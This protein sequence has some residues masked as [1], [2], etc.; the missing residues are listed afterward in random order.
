MKDYQ[1]N[2][3]TEF[4]QYQYDMLYPSGI[5]NHF[6][7]KTRHKIIEHIIYK[8]KLDTTKLL[9]VGCGKGI[10]LNYLLAQQMNIFGVELAPVTPLAG[11]EKNIITG[12]AAQELLDKESYQTLLLLDVIEHLEN[13]TEFINTL[14]THFK[15]VDTIIITVPA[16]QELWSSHDDFNQHFRRYDFEMLTDLAQ[17]T[18]LHIPYQR[19]FFNLLYIPIKLLKKRQSD[20]KAPKGL[21]KVFHSL[22]SL[23]CYLEFCLTPK[24]LYGS[25]II[26]IFKKANNVTA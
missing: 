25:S 12:K 23:Y 19:Y 20:H 13:P 18:K 22:V 14:L 10:V 17:K 8:F 5:E 9:D 7:H 6:W 24:H 3:Q 21:S 11:L 1:I 4:K 16:R 2:K 26:S 15:N